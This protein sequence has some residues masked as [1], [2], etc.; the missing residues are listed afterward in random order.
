MQKK[1]ILPRQQACQVLSHCTCV[2]PKA[3][4][5]RSTPGEQQPLETSPRTLAAL[6]SFH[7]FLPHS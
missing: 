1:G 7:H 3:A 2:S 5:S 4:A 6:G